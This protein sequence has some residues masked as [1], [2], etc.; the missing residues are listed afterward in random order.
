MIYI[1]STWVRAGGHRQGAAGVRIPFLDRFLIISTPFPSF[2]IE[3]VAPQ[4]LCGSHPGS[5][6]WPLPF[7]VGNLPSS[8]WKIKAKG[9][10]K[11]RLRDGPK[12]EA[13]LMKTL[14]L[15]GPL[16]LIDAHQGLGGMGDM[17]LEK[18][19]FRASLPQ[20]WMQRQIK[21]SK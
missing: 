5:A 13:C 16:L 3:A 19:L 1:L 10:F 4:C 8:H 11:A 2:H 7:E 17:R 20:S 9:K 21:R 18:P 14:Y 15:P 6:L 12:V